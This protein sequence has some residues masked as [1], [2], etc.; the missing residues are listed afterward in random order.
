MK[1]IKKD[2]KQVS[3]LKDITSAKTFQVIYFFQTKDSGEAFRKL[4]ANV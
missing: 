4:F 3:W 2:K 1:E